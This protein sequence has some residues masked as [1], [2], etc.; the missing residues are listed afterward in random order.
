M[1]KLICDKQGCT[2]QPKRR[3]QMAS[4][5]GAGGGGFHSSNKTYLKP[6]GQNKSK[7]SNKTGAGKTNSQILSKKLGTGKNKTN[8][9]KSSK[10]VGTGKQIKK[11]INKLKR[12]NITQSKPRKTK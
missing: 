4:K 5:L 7:S 3:K 9:S 12:L 2:L 11:V 10:K 8:K 1:R 6:L